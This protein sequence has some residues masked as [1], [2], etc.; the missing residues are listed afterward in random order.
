MTV[1][2]PNVQM[3][4]HLVPSHRER[5]CGGSV[6]MAGT[7]REP[8]SPDAR[9][10]LREAVIERLRP[11]AWPDTRFVHDLNH[12]LPAYDGCQ[13]LTDVLPALPFWPGAGLLF[14]TPDHCLEG[15]RSK[16]ILDSRPLVQTISVRLGVRYF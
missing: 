1:V 6:V 13:A 14:P 3:S 4:R 7:T 12:F 2:F 16:L 8:L 5:Q 10:Q 11:F 9:R 15:V